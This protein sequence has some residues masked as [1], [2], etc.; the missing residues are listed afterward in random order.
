MSDEHSLRD[1]N[2]YLKT[3][4]YSV[5]LVKNNYKHLV[6]EYFMFV[7]SNQN[8][9]VVGNNII[10]R[11]I[12]IRGLET[13]T[14]IFKNVLLYTNNI[15]AAL[16]HAQRG[17]CLYI[18]FITQITQNANAFIKL[19]SKDAVQYVYKKTIFNLKDRT[20]DT[21]KNSQIDDVNVIIEEFKNKI[22]NYVQNEIKNSKVEM[23]DVVMIGDMMNLLK[24]GY[25]DLK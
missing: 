7:M 23:V 5:D 20:H 22:S 4:D 10:F 25:Y 17:I 15:D 16:F 8:H 9:L 21:L 24:I 14:H 1:G 11:Y 19:S 12:I 6:S 13:I 18:E 3:W 2:T